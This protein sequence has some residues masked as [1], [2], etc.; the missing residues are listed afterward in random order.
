MSENVYEVSYIKPWE[1]RRLRELTTKVFSKIGTEKSRQRLIYDLLNTLKTNDRKGF[2]WLVLK[3]VNTLKSEE[4][5]KVKEF[6]EFLSNRYLEYE[7]TEN[8][9]KIA[10]AI[11]IGIMSAKDVGGGDRNE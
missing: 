4:R 6:V 1:L 3:N 11:V 2:L 9:E 7:T 10:Y 8:F 5:S